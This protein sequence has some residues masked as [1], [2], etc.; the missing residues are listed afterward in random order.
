MVN[1]PMGYGDLYIPQPKI[2]PDPDECSCPIGTFRIKQQL[3]FTFLH[4]INHSRP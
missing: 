1:Y 4:E 3:T 2:T